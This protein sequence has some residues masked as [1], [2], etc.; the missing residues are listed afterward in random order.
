MKYKDIFANT[1]RYC[2]H[3]CKGL[4]RDGIWYHPPRFGPP[5]CGLHLWRIFA[6]QPAVTR[7]SQTLDPNP[8]R[9]QHRTLRSGPRVLK[10]L[11]VWYHPARRCPPHREGTGSG[12]RR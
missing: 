9:L 7:G 4:S 1:S 6:G 10:E 8:P 3:T 2:W 11:Y 12:H 5:R